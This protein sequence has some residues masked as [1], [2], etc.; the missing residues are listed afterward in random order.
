MLSENFGTFFSLITGGGSVE[1]EI[2][3]KLFEKMVELK[4]LDAISAVF[5]RLEKLIKGVN[6]DKIIQGAVLGKSAASV[7]ASFTSDQ[8]VS[9]GLL[10][11]GGLEVLAGW[12]LRGESVEL[13]S[14]NPKE[15]LKL[16]LRS[17]FTGQ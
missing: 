2:A 9:E 16:T 10:R 14:I 8:P 12:L 15:D 3:T 17:D 5:T 1:I 6:P 4:G 13:L 11:G 7:L